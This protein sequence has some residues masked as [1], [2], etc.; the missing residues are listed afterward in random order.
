MT[1][2]L[3]PHIHRVWRTPNIL[4]FG[5]EEPVLTLTDLT[6]AEER[7]LVALEAGISLSGLEL[8]AT[9]AGGDAA[10]ID[11]FLARVSPVLT[12]AVECEAEQKADAPVIVI[13]GRGPT[14]ARLA[15]ILRES[16]LD[17]RSGPAW[18]DPAVDHARVAV[19]IG[20]FALEPGRHQRWLRRDIPHLPIVFGD[21]T[22]AI[23]PLV[24]PGAGPC[25]GCGERL[26]TD[27]DP[28]WPAMASQLC[29]RPVRNETSLLSSSVASAASWFVNDRVRN[30]SL[31]MTSR[32]LTIDSETGVR[33]ERDLPPHEDC[34]CRALPGTGKA[35][36]KR[37]GRPD[38]RPETR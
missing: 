19:I 4:Q 2:A 32:I 22:V 10:G 17:V 9:R 30:G 18:S 11:E 20:A 1:F 13:D 15:Q 37:G 34:G 35:D 21:R 3:D 12:S 23:G 27:A 28:D 31:R 7:M 14:A 36:A 8:V 6:N 24:E 16:G 25:V 5:V 33:S 38:F 26:R 29:A